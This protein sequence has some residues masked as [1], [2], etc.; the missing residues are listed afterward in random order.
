MSQ[1]TEIK[2]TVGLTT[3]EHVYGSR[4]M[5]QYFNLHLIEG[6]NQ[7]EIGLTGDNFGYIN[8]ALQSYLRERP[9]DIVAKA[10]REI[11]FNAFSAWDEL[12]EGVDRDMRE[13]FELLFIVRLTN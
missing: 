6:E 4:T 9:D 2:M 12:N 13:P 11:L 8:S 1:S 3:I 5:A 7:R 10:M